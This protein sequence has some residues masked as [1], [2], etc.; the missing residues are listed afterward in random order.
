MIF[1]GLDKTALQKQSQTCSSMGASWRPEWKFQRC[2]VPVSL[3]SQNPAFHR[4]IICASKRKTW[5]PGGEII[6][7]SSHGFYWSQWNFSG[8]KKTHE[9]CR[10]KVSIPFISYTH[11]L[12]LTLTLKKTSTTQFLD[13]KLYIYIYIFKNWREHK[14]PLHIYMYSLSHIE[15][16]KTIL[17]KSS[18]YL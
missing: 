15:Y 14:H 9:R 4:N 8:E 7:P 12:T 1:A 18:Y 17:C 5:L 11:T 2:S 6:P 16:E 10:I 3:C 13:C